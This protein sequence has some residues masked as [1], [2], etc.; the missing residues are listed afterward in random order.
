MPA[1]FFAGRLTGLLLFGA[2][3]A[4]GCSSGGEAPAAPKA[5]AQTAG[6]APPPAGTSASESLPPGISLYEGS[7]I[8]NQRQAKAAQALVRGYG[9]VSDDHPNV[10]VTQK[11]Q[12]AI[13]V[14]DEVKGKWKAVKLL[15]KNK[16]DEERNQMKTVGLGSS[17]RLG[18]TGM[19]VTVGPFLPNFVMT[20]AAYT[21]MSNRLDNPAVQLVVEENGKR[22]YQGWAFFKFP[23]LYAFP[24]ERF[25]IQLMDFVPEP[26]S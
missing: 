12:R 18:D 19:K 1:G 8:Q 16:A 11:V 25:S 13:A 15:I 4:V 26:V 21:S 24:H 10:Q 17:F 5:V 23:S 2:V 14:P 3:A 7:S 20:A 6:S 9:D 22:I